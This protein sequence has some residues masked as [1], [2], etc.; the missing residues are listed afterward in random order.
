MRL[1]KKKKHINNKKIKMYFS[2]KLVASKICDFIYIIIIIMLMYIYITISY[3][4]IYIAIII[5]IRITIIINIKSHLVK[6][7]LL[8]NYW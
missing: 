1:H 7:L 2:G 8:Y 4:I 3:T 5:T 6:Q